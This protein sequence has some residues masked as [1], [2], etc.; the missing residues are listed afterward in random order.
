MTEINHVLTFLV[1]KAEHPYDDRIETMQ[2]LIDF[3]NSLKRKGYIH[4]IYNKKCIITLDDNQKPVAICRG[5]T[6]GDIDWLKKEIDKEPFLRKKPMIAEFDVNE[7][8][9]KEAKKFRKLYD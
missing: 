8:E 6:Y 1:K 9:L 4:G 7:E 2:R 3:D 5:T